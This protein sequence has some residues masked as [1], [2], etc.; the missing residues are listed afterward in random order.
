[1]RQGAAR[2]SSSMVPRTTV[3][4]STL[5]SSQSTVPRTT[6]R[7]STLSAEQQQLREVAACLPMWYSYGNKHPVHLLHPRVTAL[8]KEYQP[9]NN[10]SSPGQSDDNASSSSFLLKVPTSTCRPCEQ[11][12]NGPL[13][14]KPKKNFL[15]T[16]QTI[17]QKVVSYWLIP[18]LFCLFSYSGVYK[19]RTRFK[20]LRLHTSCYFVTRHTYWV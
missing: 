4:R 6:A 1:M 2:S 14:Q 3:Q 11:P 20:I 9:A 18:R 5:R 12:F 8:Q 17:W 16:W 10:A 7:T 15:S 19:R 13:H